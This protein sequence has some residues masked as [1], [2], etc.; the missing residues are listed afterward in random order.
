MLHHF[1]EISRVRGRRGQI[2]LQFKGELSSSNICPKFG[3]C[4]RDD[5]FLVTRAVLD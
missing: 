2:L 1:Q 4:L 5:E 3:S